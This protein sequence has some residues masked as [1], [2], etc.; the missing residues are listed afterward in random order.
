MQI[1][2]HIGAH[3]T[4]NDRLIKCMLKN[5]KMLAE[6]GV[7]VP[8]PSRYRTLIRETI[9]A[10]N[11]GRPSQEA[12]DA[13]LEDIIEDEGAERVLLANEHFICVQQKILEHGV[14]Y[15]RAADRISE[16]SNLFY[17][18]EVE[19]FLAVANPATFLP[20]VAGRLKNKSFAEWYGLTDAMGLRWSDVVQRIRAANPN[21][22]MTVWCNE[23]T[24]LIWAQLMR[25]FGG[26]DH[27]VE[28]TGQFDIMAQIMRAEGRKR[29]KTYLT[30]NPPTNEIHL[31][32]IIAAFLD[33]YAVE[34][35]VEVELDLPGW[36]ED[37]VYALTDLYEEDCYAIERIPGVTFITP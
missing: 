18:H 35:E 10:L 8:G 17:G 32:R 30:E 16:L 21:A 20:T 23:D 2:L 9:Q 3:S 5:K 36:T 1:A 28:M 34:D 26:L 25:E 6:T 14:L 11:G 29:L 22:T 19:I 37:Y 27:M 15:A 7:S 31:R 13:L 12:Q 4:D 33:K 24:P